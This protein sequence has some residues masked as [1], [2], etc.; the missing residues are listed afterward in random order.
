MHFDLG[1]KLLF[2]AAALILPA[3][4]LGVVASTAGTAFAGSGPNGPTV[5]CSIHDSTVTFAPPGLSKNGS[6][7]TSKTDTTTTN[8]SS[9]E[10]GSTGGSGTLPGQ[11]ITSKATKCKGAGDPD[12]A[13]TVKGD[14]AYD[15]TAQFAAAGTTTLEKALKKV[16][17]TVS[18]GTI[19]TTTFSL[20][21]TGGSEIVE[22]A[23]CASNE[24]GFELTGDVKGP[25]SPDNY[26]GGT[27]TL[28]AC[29]L[30][31]TG[32]GTTGNFAHDIITG[33]GTIATASLDPATSTLTITS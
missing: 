31:D 24:V 15:S 22:K 5:T 1:R 2:G 32:P 30:G 17:I 9:L 16:S 21:T 29:L 11:T 28:V 25:K 6:E 13:C 20:K 8:P 27:S 33:T 23:P 12:P 7:N 4:T 10:C 26:K 14:Y 18:G 3:A 19:G